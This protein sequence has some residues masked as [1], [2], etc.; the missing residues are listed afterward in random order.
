MQIF[1]QFRHALNQLVLRRDQCMILKVVHQVLLSMFAE[2]VK[3][4]L[5]RDRR[6]LKVIESGRVL[7]LSPALA[8]IHHSLDHF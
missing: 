4:D 3:F 2:E 1:I 5:A 6:P 7:D 8:R